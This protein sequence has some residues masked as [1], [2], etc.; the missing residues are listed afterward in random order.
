M[1][2]FDVQ[3]ATT[4]VVARFHIVHVGEHGSERQFDGDDFTDMKAIRSIDEADR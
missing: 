3:A 2:L 1:K 4:V